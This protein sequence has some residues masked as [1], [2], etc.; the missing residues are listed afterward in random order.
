MEK[1]YTGCQHS[2]LF[3]LYGPMQFRG[4]SH[5][6]ILHEFRH[7]HS[8]LVPETVAISFLAGNIFLNFFGLFG[9]CVCIYC[10]GC[11]L[12]STFTN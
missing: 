11:S 12:V 7:Q 4:A 10:F 1:H 2:T 5:G 3:V 8:F 9:E 6:S